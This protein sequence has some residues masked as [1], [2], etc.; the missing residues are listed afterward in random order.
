MLEIVG[1]GASGQASRDWHEVWKGSQECQYVEEEIENIKGDKL[2]KPA[3][4]D[5]EDE[6]ISEFA[7]PFSSQLYHVTHRA[8]QQYWRL[9]EYIMAKIALGVIAGLFV[10]FSNFKSDNSLQGLQNIIFSI[11]MV[12][13][14]FS[15]LVQQVSSPCLPSDKTGDLRLTATPDHASLRHTTIS[16]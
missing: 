15:T 11:F 5:G 4:N 8:F 9:P 3:A 1:A 2:S 13:T 6:A 10:G 16:V 12:I 7:M 14:I